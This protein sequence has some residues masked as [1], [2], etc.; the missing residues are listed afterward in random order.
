MSLS[1]KKASC[2]SSTLPG[3]LSTT[4][5]VSIKHWSDLFTDGCNVHVRINLCSSAI[6]CSAA[7]Y[8][9]NSS[10]EDQWCYLNRDGFGKLRRWCNNM[11]SINVNNTHDNYNHCNSSVVLHPSTQ[12]NPTLTAR[13]YYC[14]INTLRLI[15]SGTQPIAGSYR[16]SFI[17]RLCK[18]M[19]ILF[20]CKWVH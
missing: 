9:Y 4:F 8:E 10:V 18:C 2:N 19:L 16:C 5:L 3:L 15:T 7:A 6:P 20:W 14:S 13:S 1:T 12:K 11:F 17:A